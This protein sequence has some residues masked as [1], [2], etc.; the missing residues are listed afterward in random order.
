MDSARHQ[1]AKALFLGALGLAGKERAA[2]LE[3]ECAGDAELRGHVEGLLEADAAGRASFEPADVA[4]DLVPGYRIVALR[5]EGGMGV[6]YDAIQEHPVRRRVALKLIRFGLVT[7]EMVARFEAERQ[8]LALMSH[9]NIARIYEAG[10][11]RQG[12]PFFAMEFVGGAPLTTY[13]DDERLPP[14]RRLELYADVCDGVHH[15]HQKG[16]IHRDIKPS[17]VLVEIEGDRP[18]PKIIDFGVAKAMEQPLTAALLVTRQGRIVGT[19]E[20][21]SPEQAEGAAD[22]DIRTD[23]YALGALLYELLVG[24]RPLERAGEAELSLE[25]LLAAIRETDPVA[26]SRCLADLERREEIAH[27][28]RAEGASLTRFL[29]SGLDWIVMKALEKDRTRRY[30][31]AAELRADILRFLRNEPVLA[32][33]PTIRYRAGR[34]VRRHR[35]GVTAAAAVFAALSTGLALATTALWKQQR[36]ERTA[37]WEADTARQVSEFLVGLFDEADPQK[38]AG[39]EITVREVVDRGARRIDGELAERPEVRARLKETLGRV[40][41]GLGLL[42]AAEPLLVAAVEAQRTGGAEGVP[43]AASLNSLAALRFRQADYPAAE[44]LYRESRDALHRVSQPD[45][46][47]DLERSRT[48]LFLGETLRMTGRYEEAEPPSREALEIREKWLGRRHDHVAECLHHLALIRRDRGEY[49]EA[50]Q[51]LRE[52]LDIERGLLGE[53]HPRYAMTLQELAFTVQ[54]LGDYDAA[55]PLLRK[56]LEIDRRTLGEQHPD[57]TTSLYNLA[58]LLHKRGSLDEAVTLLEQVV[59]LDRKQLGDEHLYV[60]LSMNNLATVLVDAA[61]YGEA[62]ELFRRA[63]E[64]QERTQGLEHPEVATTVSNL[65]NLLRVTGRTE[66]A[67]AAYRRALAIRRKLLGENHLHVAISLN[68]LADILRQKRE[69]AEAR[70]MLDEALAIRRA[71]ASGD[72]PGIALNLLSLAEVAAAAGD[73]GAEPLYRESLAVHRRTLRDRHPRIAFPLLGLG[74]YLIDAARAAEAE[75]CLREAVAIR[76]AELGASH[77]L[78]AQAHAALGKCLAAEERF[79]EAE[80]HLLNGLSVLEEEW[81]VEDR[82]LEALRDGIARFYESWGKPEV[83]GRYRTPP[84]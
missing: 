61:R 27:K 59:E 40:Y 16:I 51:L 64:V 74:N 18:V 41:H 48:L 71:A 39:R 24:R 57:L 67:E 29:R 13:C 49:Q 72:N 66:E 82:R 5:G 47:A 7:P 45:R 12:L 55:E 56:A 17:N 34:F 50:E 26:P 31:S 60:T 22:I 63:L 35:L 78:S 53:E 65:G 42:D 75:P 62:E 14:R 46:S 21:L 84:E 25:G 44:S 3:R 76:D 6:V 32:G 36:A 54:E 58:T 4:T 33:P 1:R 83:A 69:F 80:P 11:T 9:P 43:L 37:R 10:V 68:H 30:S 81:G 38:S 2:L 79:A 52:A 19:P 8:A 73:S 28:R 70:R 77:P 23:V 15:A 20:Y